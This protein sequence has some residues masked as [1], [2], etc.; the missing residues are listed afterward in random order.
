[1]PG[2]R[3]SGASVSTQRILAT[4]SVTL[5]VALGSIAVTVDAANSEV[6]LALEP[7][8]AS[9]LNVSEAEAPR[10]STPADDDSCFRLIG[11]IITFK[12]WPLTSGIENLILQELRNAGY[13]RE[14]IF[15]RSHSWEVDPD[16]DSDVCGGVRDTCSKLMRDTRISSVVE[17]CEPDYLIV[18]HPITYQGSV[19][20][21]N[22][23]G[24]V[25]ER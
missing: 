13:R 24:V 6:H 19:V 7:A 5:A 8:A 14:D 16:Y 23:R 18:P 9:N 15:P 4:L 22:G 20:I 17:S 1:M 21:N 12:N 10:Q 3:A 11:F 25:M 2:K